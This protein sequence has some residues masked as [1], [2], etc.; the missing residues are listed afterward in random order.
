MPDASKLSVSIDRLNDQIVNYLIDHDNLEFDA[1]KFGIS[2]SGFYLTTDLT[3]SNEAIINEAI[4]NIGNN[5]P[6]WSS[7]YAP[8]GDLINSYAI[9][10][11]NLV[12]T[13]M[14]SFQKA[15]Y[16]ELRD[17]K[18]ELQNKLMDLLSKN[19]PG[20]RSLSPAVSKLI[21]QLEQAEET[22]KTILRS[23]TSIKPIVDVLNSLLPTSKS[24]QA[25]PSLIE[26]L[27]MVSFIT[28]ARVLTEKNIYNMPVNTYPP[29]SSNSYSPKYVI[30]GFDAVFTKWKDI[31]TKGLFPITIQA[32]DATADES[33]G[34]GAFTPM[35]TLQDALL[36]VNLDD[37]GSRSLS[38]PEEEIP[39]G[40]YTATAK[41]SGL[42]AFPIK[43]GIWFEEAFFE[44]T[45]YE[46]LSGAP[47]FFA[48][49]GSL[50]L[51]PTKV[52]LAYN[53]TLEIGLTKAKYDSLKNKVTSRSPDAAL[54]LVLGSANLILSGP[55]KNVNINFLNETSAAIEISPLN[56]NVPNLLGVVS[57]KSKNIISFTLR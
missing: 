25:T 43:P 20:T 36:L 56:N 41:F 46:L 5:L 57:Q 24:T 26:A 9:F 35:A 33:W 12:P 16:R 42:G 27:G 38:E 11:D 10:L 15:T 44:Q 22:A 18:L 53:F 17:T 8:A 51:I 23:V 7:S 39:A 3:N 37:T 55:Q 2:F 29:S 47:N 54:G 19:K 48:D 49:D 21:A 52:I 4:F 6:R 50:A 32:T 40:H 13:D 31:A 28:G 34:L 14:P 1:I 30:E 45:Q